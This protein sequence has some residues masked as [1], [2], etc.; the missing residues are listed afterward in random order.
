MKQLF[1]LPFAIA[2]LLAVPGGALANDYVTGSHATANVT[3]ND[4]F[5]WVLITKATVSILPVLD[6]GDHGCTVTASADVLW[7]GGS[8]NEVENRYRFV[9]IRNNT[10]PVTGLGT[11]RTLAMVNHADL[12]DPNYHAIST[13]G[14]SGG[15]TNNNGVN[16]SGEHTFY[17]L[18]RKV[19]ASDPNVTVTDASLAVMCVD[20][21]L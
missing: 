10:N 20:D 16:G 9:V 2:C 12:N 19:S 7:T 18:G 13:T 4:A 5:N 21:T 3:I 17:F 11:E 6:N 8:T 15:L 14:V 1:S